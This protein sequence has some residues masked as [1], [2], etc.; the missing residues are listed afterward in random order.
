M[1]SNLMNFDHDTRIVHNL[2]AIPKEAILRSM[3]FT[4]YIEAS[5][6]ITAFQRSME[7]KVTYL[8]IKRTSPKKAFREFI[9]LYNVKAYYA[10]FNCGRHRRDDTFQVYYQTKS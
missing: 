10:R 8:S 1:L 6:Q 7:T 5:R 3:P 9:D 2:K 4:A